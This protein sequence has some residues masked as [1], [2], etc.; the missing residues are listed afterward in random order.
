MKLFTKI[1]AA[2]GLMILTSA[3]SAL[4][5]TID[6]YANGIGV[7]ATVTGTNLVGYSSLTDGVIGNWDL[8]FTA[9]SSSQTSNPLM[10]LNAFAI[11]GD[12]GGVLK[13]TL[14]DTDF[15][16]GG[17]APDMT[18][19]ISDIGGALGG[20][21]IDYVALLTDGNDTY[22][23]GSANHSGTGFSDVDY[24]NLTVGANYA[25]DMKVILTADK[26]TSGS[27]DASIA[28]P[29]PATLA[30]LGLGLVGLG[31]SRKKA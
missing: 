14:S 30:L 29:A 6:D 11:S 16:F 19:F 12:G 24:A 17:N 20:F 15:I 10:H 31:W 28:V 22:T 8:V 9:G 5:L 13:I 7:D 25:L 18:N 26:A 27:I 21:T 4:T 23:I 1:I 2:T 3:A